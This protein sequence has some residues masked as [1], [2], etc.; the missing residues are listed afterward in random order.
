MI[1]LQ[2]SPIYR[3]VA[4]SL[5]KLD[6]HHSVL[7]SLDADTRERLYRVVTK[8]VIGYFLTFGLVFCLGLGLL[9][10]QA[11]RVSEESAIV[12]FYLNLLL[13]ANEVIQGDW[14]PGIIGK[15]GVILETV[16]LLLPLFIPILMVSFGVM[17]LI[18]RWQI[19]KALT[20][21]EKSDTP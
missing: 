12:R 9:I 6:E 15:R 1:S 13:S 5:E 20:Q 21:L 11:W 10:T 8:K 4:Y 14:G 16:I 17:A 3:Y 7:T 18:T 19:K 2:K